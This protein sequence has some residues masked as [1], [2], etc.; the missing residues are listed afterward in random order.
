LKIPIIAEGVET[1]AQHALLLREGCNEV[2][3]YLT[4][5]PQLIEDYCELTG[6]PG[7]VPG[8]ADKAG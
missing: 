3:G 2:Q 1:Q 8:R 5:R 6:R 7:R 4:G